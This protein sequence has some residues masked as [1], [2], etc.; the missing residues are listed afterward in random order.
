MQRWHH[1]P[2]AHLPGAPRVVC[3]HCWRGAAGAE[4][5]HDAI[6]TFNRFE[7]KYVVPVRDLA[8]L[9]DEIAAYMVRDPHAGADGRYMLSS[10]YY[11]TPAR[12]CF[13]A[14]LDGLKFRR[15]LRIRHYEERVSLKGDSP[16]FIE[17]K[18][19]VDRVTQKRRAVLAYRDAL[20]L[21]E[22]RVIPDHD[23]QDEAV[24]HE[25]FAL[26]VRHDLR[27]ACI[28]TY[29]REP[30]MG[31]DYDPGLRITIDTDLRYRTNDLWLDS[32]HP[33]RF[34]FP[35]RLAILEIKANDRVP[36]WLTHLVARN[37]LQLSRMSKYC[38]SLDVAGYGQR[39]A[40][41]RRIL[42][43]V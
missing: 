18:Q 9:R 1:S 34:M 41:T 2:S 40:R 16:V 31:G 38:M 43:A 33:G 23:E 17:I 20:D 36:F 35:P 10:L 27:P 32:K 19:R 14:K 22:E 28:T 12:D 8:G 37:N 29:Q 26:V 30:W 5:E 7:L 3:A 15:K 13:W 21:C 39:P 4:I 6:R 42:L 24:V 11:D 25:A